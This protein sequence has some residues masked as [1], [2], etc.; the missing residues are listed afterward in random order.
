VWFDAFVTNVEILHHN[1]D[2]YLEASPKS[3]AQIRSHVLLPWADRV[4]DLDED[5][6]ARLSL[7]VITETL[8]EQLEVAI[9]PAL[10]HRSR[11]IA[12]SL[13]AGQ[14][15]ANIPSPLFALFRPSVQP[16]SNPRCDAAR[17]R[18]A[19]WTSR[20]PRRHES[21]AQAGR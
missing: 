11:E 17:C 19:T 20:F 6:A 10:R 21:R 14:T 15:V 18:C 13:L 2:G 1:W 7:D 5:L 16:Y 4:A 12:A 8:L 3:F 9:S